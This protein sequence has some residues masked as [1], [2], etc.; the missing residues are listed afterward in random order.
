MTV[1]K[2]RSRSKSFTPAEFETF[3]RNAREG[4]GI[5]C[6]AGRV[7]MSDEDV[8]RIFAESYK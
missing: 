4:R 3:T 6:T 1:T 5:V 7:P 2:C 8:V